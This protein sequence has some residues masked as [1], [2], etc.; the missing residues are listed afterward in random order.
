MTVLR[1]K[2]AEMRINE[3]EF[4]YKLWMVDSR[5]IPMTTVAFSGRV[6]IVMTTWAA[7]WPIR[8]RKWADMG[9]NP[10]LFAA[11]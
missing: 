1:N 9:V 3:K 4:E 5:N 2:E 7:S 10:N 11:P 6:C 8:G